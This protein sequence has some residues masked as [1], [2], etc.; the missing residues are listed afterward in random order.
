MK[1]YLAFILCLT[2]L[3]RLVSQTVESKSI[4]TLSAVT[5]GMNQCIKTPASQSSFSNTLGLKVIERSELGYP[6]R[7]ICNQSQIYESSTPSSYWAAKLPSLLGLTAES[8]V[9]YVLQKE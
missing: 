1:Q 4:A 3:C 2:G 9:G 5:F 6:V 8:A 7:F